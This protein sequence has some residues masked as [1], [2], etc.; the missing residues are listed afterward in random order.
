MNTILLYAVRSEYQRALRNG[1]VFVTSDLSRAVLE[2]RIIARRRGKRMFVV[3]FRRV[4]ARPHLDPHLT[5]W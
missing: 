5:S 2:A 4:A 3:P 1:Q